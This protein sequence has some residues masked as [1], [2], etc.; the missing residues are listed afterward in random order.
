MG[1]SRDP[2]LITIPTR[3]TPL[4][5][6]AHLLLL[7]T[8]TP[9]QPY[10]YAARSDLVLTPVQ[11]EPEAMKA[12]STANHPVDL[13]NYGERAWCRLETYMFMVG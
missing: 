3:R 6:H 13:V 11:S 12:Y 10:Q 5:T 7:L 9:S 4:P 8:F 2:S 1:A